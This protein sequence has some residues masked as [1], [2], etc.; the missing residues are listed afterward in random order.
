MPTLTI[1][2]FIAV[3]TVTAVSTSRVMGDWKTPTGT[4]LRVEPCGTAV[5]LRVVRISPSAP[6]TTD[7]HNPDP[8]LHG[9]ALC[10]L[11]VGTGFHQDDATHL[12]DGRLYDPVSGH[13]F[14]GTVTVEGNS[15]HLRGYIGVPLFGRS[16]T[17][18]RVEP[19]TACK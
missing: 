3:G 11:V 5:C 8:A 13:T 2:L 17:W 4:I 6:A 19:V 16:E 1:S 7:I 15:L 18:Q 9:R 12:S 14:R 10:G